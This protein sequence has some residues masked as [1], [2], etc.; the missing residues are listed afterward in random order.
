MKQL[1][2]QLINPTER[3]FPGIS[4]IKEEFE[5]WDYRFGKTP[6]FT[7]QKDLQLKSENNRMYDVKLQIDVEKVNQL[8]FM[9]VFF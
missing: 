4:A 5:S 8:Y 6:K 9:G 2:F 1:G 7:I 3:W